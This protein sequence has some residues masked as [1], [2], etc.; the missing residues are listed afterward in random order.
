MRDNPLAAVAG[1]AGVIAFAAAY[2]QWGVLPSYRLRKAQRPGPQPE[3]KESDRKPING[4]DSWLKQ[5]Q[6]SKL[7][8]WGRLPSYEPDRTNYQRK[9]D[10]SE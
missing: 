10:R 7:E 6:T 2:V 4:H 8:S 9:G 3:P 1:L 5:A